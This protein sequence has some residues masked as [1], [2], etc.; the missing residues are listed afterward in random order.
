MAG[1]LPSTKTHVGQTQPT[2][3]Q[4][5]EW[6]WKGHGFDPR[7]PVCVTPQNYS[8]AQNFN[9][10]KQITQSSYGNTKRKLDHIKYAPI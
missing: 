5:G 9:P 7:K 4:S 8:L 2:N 1:P 10:G 3:D 6:P